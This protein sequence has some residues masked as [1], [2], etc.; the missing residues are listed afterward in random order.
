MVGRREWVLV[1]RRVDHTVVGV[2]DRSHKVVDRIVAGDN[3][4]C[5]LVRSLVAGNLVGF[6]SFRPFLKDKN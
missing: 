4:G 6:G 5:R 2:V 3:L 1:D